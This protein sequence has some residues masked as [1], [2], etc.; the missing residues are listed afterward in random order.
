M[1]ANSFELT[2]TKDLSFYR[3]HVDVKQEGGSPKPSKLRTK[4]LFTLLLEHSDYRGVV[5]D[6]ASVLLSRKKLEKVPGSILIPFRAQGTDETPENPAVYNFTIQE[7]GTV[8]VSDLIE[9]LKSVRR[10]IPAFGQRNEVLQALNIIF[11]HFPQL[12]SDVATIG[13][14]KQHYS[15]DRQ[16]ANF[17]D[18]GGGIEA[19][20]GYYKSVRP[21]T[22]R[23][24]LN[25][26]VTHAVC[27]KPLRLDNILREFGSRDILDLS[28]KLKTVRLQRLHLPPKKNKSGEVIPS[29]VTFWDFATNNDGFSEGNRPQVLTP[30]GAGPKGVKF[31]LNDMG[32]GSTAAQSS[33]TTGKGGSAPG[34]ST[35]TGKYISVWDYFRQSEL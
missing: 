15:I 32:A 3:Y 13:R 10:D 18:L 24:L 34:K 26:N 35:A 22:C 7:T 31:F 4:R 16:S 2:A 29:V 21:A 25:V 27:F 19:L 5:T 28:R 8:L 33:K 17:H 14:D 23:L 6:Y 30:I 9:W 20:R 12:Q 11:G 1:Y